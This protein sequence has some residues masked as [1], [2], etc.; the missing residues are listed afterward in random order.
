MVKAD[1]GS[2]V[3][4]N[5]VDGLFLYLIVPERQ[6]KTFKQALES[7]SLLDKSTKIKPFIGGSDD[8]VIV[9]ILGAQ[10]TRPVIPDH[11]VEFTDR[12]IPNDVDFPTEGNNQKYAI[13]TKLELNGTALRDDEIQITKIKYTI[14]EKIGLADL[15]DLK[16]QLMFRNRPSEWLNESNKSPLAKAVRQWLHSVPQPIHSKLPAGPDEL[17]NACKWTY[18][19]YTPMLLLPPNFLSKDPWPNLLANALRPHLPELY[20]IICRYLKVTH[21]AIN[22]PIPALLTNSKN[23][24]T[25]NILRSPS[26]LVPLHG[27]FGESNLPATEQNL[28]DAFWVSATQNGIVQVWAPLYTMFS[29]GNISEKT[30]LLKLVSAL[31]SQQLTAVDLY[32]GIGYFAFS[33]A[34]AGVDKILCWELNGWSI[35]GLRRGTRENGWRTKIVDG[36]QKESVLDDSNQDGTG[37]GEEL[38]LVFHESNANAAERVQKLRNRI[39]PIRHVNCGYLP[40]SRD[41]WDVAVQILDSVKGGWIHA[42]ENVPIR[43]IEERKDE[44]VNL[45]KDLVHQYRTPD[46]AAPRFTVECHHVEQVKAYAPGIIHCVFEITIQPHPA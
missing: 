15:P 20:D 33:F 36:A 16:P 44:I 7:N 40:S 34:K 41:S 1:D 35:E 6:V 26:N 31:P 38:F 45:F 2:N 32:A 21:I 14:L 18:M 10:D 25:S 8:L 11:A 4:S 24:S 23:I 42:H 29:R 39:P 13:P 19:V 12:L 37:I 30:R 27:A 3:I 17:L 5:E 43:N 28:R 46:P 9:P 22:G